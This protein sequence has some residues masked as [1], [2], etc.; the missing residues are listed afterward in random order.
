[1]RVVVSDTGPV[2]HLSE[3]LALDLLRET[4]EVHIPEAVEAELRPHFPDW[5]ARRPLWLIVDALAASSGGAAAAWEAAGLLDKGESAAIALAQELKAEWLFTDDAA[6]RIFA[7]A[8]GIEV[9]G[10][11]GVV[12]WVAAQGYLSRAD[13]EA[14]LDRLAQSSLWVSARVMAEARAALSQLTAGP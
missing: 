5:P 1:L 7:K 13:A 3:A 10:S 6:A 8:V 4:G 14:C 2:L 12:L 9:H 11:L